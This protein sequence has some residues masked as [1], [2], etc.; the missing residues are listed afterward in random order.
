MYQRHFNVRKT[1][2]KEPIPGRADMAVN[3][4]G[5]YVWDV[6]DWKRLDR[7]LILGAEGGTYYVK[8]HKLTRENAEAV[9]RCINAD[10]ERVVKQVV[11]ISESGRA[12]KNDPA[13]FVLAMCAGLGDAKTRSAALHSLNRVARTGTYLFTFATYIQAFR[14]WGRGLRD[15][16]GSWYTEKSAENLAYQL[17]KYRQRGGWTHRD[18]LRLSHP[19]TNSAA[20]KIL[21]D[22]ICHGKEWLMTVVD[23]GEQWQKF[24][25]GYELASITDDAKEIVRLVSD[26]KLPWEALDTKWLRSPKVWEVLLPNTP[27]WALMRNLGRLS[28]IGLLAPLSETSK[29]V[30]QRFSDVEALSRSRLHPFTILLGM[31]TYA[32]G[33]GARGNLKWQPVSQVVDAL[34]AAFYESFQNVKPTG[35]RFV[36]AVDVS[37]SMTSSMGDSPL[38]VREA[39]AAM[40]MV[41][42]RTEPNYTVVAFSDTMVPIEVSPRERL[43]DVVRKFGGL[44][45]GGTDCA[46]PMLW[47]L[48]LDVYCTRYPRYWSRQLQPQVQQKRDVVP[49]DCF[50]VY[51]DNE[52]WA[53]DI[54][55]VQALKQYRRETG[56]PAKLITVG[57][58]SEG[59]TIADPNDVGMLDVV[60]FD[61]ACPQVIQ[62]FIEEP[63]KEA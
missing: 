29:Y 54:H 14:G 16:V 20:H 22:W 7:F 50:I 48:G 39:A 31:R 62:Q 13:L 19:E 1:S 9:L 38:T 55:P 21:L 6:D 45:F 27:L 58:T 30:V 5:G 24:V 32:A 25:V 28:D 34:D 63:T 60:G 40:A 52:T 17:V 8:E 42:A 49:A 15:A 3:E 41:T 53:G 47:A 59:F 44:A 35:K 10:G 43:D 18:L 36:L 33:H 4:A 61:S 51:T 23:T 37:G 57:M 11:E 26:C 46:L 12:P 2:Q 56:I